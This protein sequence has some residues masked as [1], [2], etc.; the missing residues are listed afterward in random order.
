MAGL[1]GK[2]DGIE[3]PAEYWFMTEKMLV[4]LLTIKDVS[5]NFPHIGDE[6]DG[7]VVELMQREYGAYR[8]LLNT[9]AY[10]FGR[11]DFL[12]ADHEKDN[13]TS[14]ILNIGNFTKDRKEWRNEKLPSKFEQ[15][16]YYLLGRDFGTEHEQSLSS[17]AVRWGTYH[18]QHMGMR[19]HYPL[20][21]L[22][23]EALLLLIQAPLHIT[24]MQMAQLFQR[25]CCT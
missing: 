3:F 20:F 25:Y 24:P 5:D 7:Y 19:M 18:L 22:Q 6:D 16:G 1:S 9:G 2:A 11:E 14:V 23:E 10:L 13:K 4:Y 15:G 12:Q 8:S 17:I 21:F